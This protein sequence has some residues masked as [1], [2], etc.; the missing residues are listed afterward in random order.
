MEETMQLKRFRVMLAA[1]A[2]TFAAAAPLA[3]DTIRL[4]NGSVIRGQVVGF[5]D[6]QFTVLMEPTARGRRNQIT[7]Y[8]EEVESIEFDGAGASSAASAPDTETS[9]PAPASPNREPQREPQRT[10]SAPTLGQ[11]QRPSPNDSPAASAPRNTNAG[12]QVPA[13]SSSQFFPVRVRV[14]A[15]N[16]ANG[17]TDSGLMVRKGQR[18]RISASGRVS[19]GQGRFSTPTGLPR[20]VDNEKL[21][22][23]EAT[24]ALIAVVG[25]DNDDFIFVGANREFYAPRDGR[26]FLGVNEGNLN[27]NTG[28]YDAL[29]E[30]EP[31]ASGQVRP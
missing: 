12:A 1:A 24:G 2:L 31:V 20:V 29:I 9:R 28:T 5:R 23:D 4:K 17:W 14:R 18:L 22:K 11:Q 26:L 6:E 21:M 16:T 13:G 10:S 30:A 19:L 3:A 7:V 8:M 25:D 15:D 27:D